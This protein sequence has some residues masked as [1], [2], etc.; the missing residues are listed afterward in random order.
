MLIVFAHSTVHH[1][2]W[3]LLVV[4][5]YLPVS[6]FRRSASSATQFCPLPS[7]SGDVMLF[8]QAY[9]FPMLLDVTLHYTFAHVL[10]F[11][12]FLRVP[13]LNLDICVLFIILITFVNFTTNV[14]TYN[15][16]V[17]FLLVRSWQKLFFRNFRDRFPACDIYIIIRFIFMFKVD[18][19]SISVYKQLSANSPF[20][21][22]YTGTLFCCFTR[23]H[24]ENR[25][26]EC[27]FGSAVVVSCNVEIR[28]SYEIVVFY[29]YIV[30]DCSLFFNV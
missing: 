16:F 12:K 21:L 2:P 19:V 25:A 26:G 23:A 6:V 11:Y 8:T 18:L 5:Q 15:P 9:V 1:E 24:V 3:P 14:F 29:Q 10:L 17:F 7:I 13:C 20:N 28:F 27:A 30:F 4:R 22:F